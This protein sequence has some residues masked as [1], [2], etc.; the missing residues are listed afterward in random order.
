[1]NTQ[2]QAIWWGV[3]AATLVASE[4]FAQ[5]PV[6]ID[7]SGPWAFAYTPTH[8]ASVPPANAFSA[9]M[10]VPGCWDDTFPPEHARRLWA[11]ARFN[12]RYQPVRYPME[13]K[14]PDAS[15][16]FLLGTGWYRRTLDVPGD[17]RGRQVTLR[18]GRVVME[19]YV[20]LNGQFLHHHK[21]YST[22]WEVPLGEHLRY[23][24]PNELV[25]AVDNTPADR[26]GSA[27]RGWKGRSAGIFGPVTLEVAG[28]ARIAD[29][30]VYP[31]GN[32]LH[33]QV[34]LEG[35]V[36]DACR[37]R[38]EVRD[39]KGKRT[40]AKGDAAV[41]APTTRWETDTLG[42][43]SWSDKRPVLYWLQV[44]LWDEHRLLDRRRQRFG[45]RRLTTDGTRLRLN[46]RPIFLRGSCDHAY[47]PITCTLPTDMASYRAY[48]QRLKEIGFNWIRCHTWVPPEPYLQAA[49]ELGMLVQVEAPVGYTLPEWRDILHACRKH[50]CVV[51]YCCGNEGFLDEQMIEFLRQCAAEQK[52][53]VPDALFNPQEA[54]RGVEYGLEGVTE[55]V[56]AEP[57]VHHP[58]RLA[59]LKEFSDVFGQYTWGWLSYTSLEGIPERI[60]E[61]LALYERPCL[62]HELGICG[63]Y[64]D[65][66]LEK[67]YRGTRIGPD[68]FA[69]AREI[70]RQTG[71]LSR[72]EIYYRH[73]AAWQWLIL[74][75]ALETARRCRLLAGYDLLGAIDG[76]WHRTGYECGLLNEFH[77]LKPGRTVADILSAN[78]E[79]VLLIERQRERVL[80]AGESFQRDVFVSWFG[81]DPLQGTLHW[82]LRD[83]S[84]HRL[85]QGTSAVPQV[86]PGTVARLATVSARL[87]ALHQPMKTTLEV[88]L[89][90]PAGRI[91][92]TWDYWIFPEVANDIPEGVLVVSRLDNAALRALASGARVVLL[93][94]EPF[95]TK[96]LSFQMALAGRP[97]GNMA[98]VIARHP[99]MDRFP[100]EGY[101]DWQ[102]YALFRGARVVHFDAFPEAFDPILDV[103]SSYKHPL[104]QAAIFEWRVGPGR[105]LV[106]SLNLAPTDPAAAYLRRQI[107]DYAAGPAFQPRVVVAPEALAQWLRLPAP[108]QREED[109]SDRAYDERGQVS[110]GKE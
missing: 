83:E 71:L 6:R 72:A 97:E 98:T 85:A 99:I 69:G 60:D 88:A 107:L 2:E 9:S 67:R 81:E 52:E 51:I 48:L 59:R 4:A 11:N 79:S 35:L 65:L 80:R 104:R 45:M 1:M 12:P 17:W 28:S 70:L 91:R 25:I 49:D 95:P 102:F 86:A 87:P 43:E 89:E 96:P 39:P 103:A 5:V 105:L 66:R 77:E 55:G 62:S 13:G 64:L 24:E 84:G 75:D 76:H 34:R 106:C 33:W 31:D 22:D 108:A 109:G 18:V 93:G 46:G 42:L 100:H 90:S 15:L 57:F 37:L 36:P 19:G 16:P 32:T 30:Y 50:P 21:G 10:P 82:G 23:G 61:R 53:R 63:C 27:I 92:N 101:C 78:G 44:E 56:V 73:S 38:W 26:I 14:P 41:T 3:L 54:L 7:L 8:T 47:F 68:L 110:S 20:Y 40:V 74:K 94:W 29:L 58:A